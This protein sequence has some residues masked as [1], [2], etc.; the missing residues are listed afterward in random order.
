MG[1]KIEGKKEEAI[2]LSPKK[3]PKWFIIVLILIPVLFFVLLEF[4][5]RFFNY[6]YDNRQWISGTDG[7]LFLNPE[8]AKR[9]FY[10]FPCDLLPE[11]KIFS[12]RIK[13]MIANAFLPKVCIIVSLT[14]ITKNN[15]PPK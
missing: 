7:E 8:I 4:S 6:G 10:R 1:K 13:K 3:Y 14:S 15:M 11:K 5:L 9:Y 2:S 12:N